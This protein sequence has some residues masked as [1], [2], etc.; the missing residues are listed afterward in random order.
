MTGVAYQLQSKTYMELAAVMCAAAGQ[1]GD[2][3]FDLTDPSEI[4]PAIRTTIDETRR[5]TLRR[6]RQRM[7]A[8]LIRDS[9][10][11]ASL[12]PLGSVR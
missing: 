5:I 9:Q 1:T 11:T 3:A 7:T 12:L 2:C 8:L 10:I 4:A 6:E